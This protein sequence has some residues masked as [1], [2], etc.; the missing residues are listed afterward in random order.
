MH[1]S[2]KNNQ[3]ALPTS[4]CSTTDRPSQH[5]KPRLSDRDENV[6]ENAQRFSVGEAIQPRPNSPKQSASVSAAT[7]RRGSTGS[8]T[9]TKRSSHVKAQITKANSLNEDHGLLV[10]I[11]N[12]VE[13]PA[14]DITFAFIIV[15]NS[16]A[17]L[18]H[19]GGPNRCPIRLSKTNLKDYSLIFKYK[20]EESQ[21]RKKYGSGVF[22]VL[23]CLEAVLPS[24]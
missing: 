5:M 17:I 6:V 18:P 12:F 7:I 11:Q 22:T 4:D 8:S 1:A 24:T 23:G 20:M 21:R 14:F 10:K 15:L 3:A 16:L 19:R 13:N 9:P 2:S